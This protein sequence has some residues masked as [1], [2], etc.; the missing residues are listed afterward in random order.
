MSFINCIK[1][2]LNRLDHKNKIQIKLNNN[3]VIIVFITILIRT[4]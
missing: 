3:I 4:S 1:L 2:L